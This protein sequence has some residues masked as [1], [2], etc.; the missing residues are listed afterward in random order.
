MTEDKRIPIMTRT[1][2]NASLSKRLDAKSF[3]DIEKVLTGSIEMVGLERFQGAVESVMSAIDYRLAFQTDAEGYRMIDGSCSARITAVCQRC[4]DAVE[5]D[6]EGEFQVGL[7]YSD[8][9]AKHLPK[10]YEP[11]LMDNNGNIDP[12]ELLEDELILALP[13]FANHELGECEV[14]Q[15]VAEAAHI[16]TTSERDNPFDVLKQFKSK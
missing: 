11:V 7:A 14:K 6:V 8:E 13:M 2:A 4:L 5:L 12:Y 1:M 10:H 15:P 9:E 16:E 3:V